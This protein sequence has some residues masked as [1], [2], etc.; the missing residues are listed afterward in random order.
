[1]ENARSIY[2]SGQSNLT[3]YG[4]W[5]AIFFELSSALQK[6]QND[7]IMTAVY[8]Y[9]SRVN[10]IRLRPFPWPSCGISMFPRLFSRLGRGH[11]W[12]LP[13]AHPHDAFGI[14][15]SAP[16]LRAFRSPS[17]ECSHCFWFTLNTLGWENLAIFDRNRRLSR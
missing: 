9:S 1:M 16:R 4:I 12:P 15:F 14:W 8:K 2:F 11:H 13:T 5:N 7:Q 6:R 17:L 3:S 10:Q